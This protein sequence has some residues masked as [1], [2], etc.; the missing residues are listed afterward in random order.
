M[1]PGR[2]VDRKAVQVP[3]GKR[4]V[5]DGEA[6]GR[7]ELR[8][9]R[10]EPGEHL[11][12][13][14]DHAGCEASHV[15]RVR[16]RGQHQPLRLDLAALGPHPH[17]VLARRPLE[18]ALPRPQLGAV[19][20]R[21]VDVRDDAA[22]GHDEAALALVDEPQLGRQAISREPARDLGAV[23]LFVLEAVLEA[24]A[25]GALE[26][27][28]TAF[29]G[30][31]H[32]QQLLAG[33]GLELAPQLVR[34]QHE[35]HVARVLEVRLADDPR[36]AVRGAELVRHVEALETEDALPA[37]REVV[38]RSAPHAADPDDDDVVALHPS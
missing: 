30:A 32:V 25:N 23:E 22:L 13:R 31:R 28:R 10:L 26:D 1:N 9:E 2:A 27:P 34:A 8:P 14:R 12:L 7:E 35:R 20:E 24:R 5:E 29:D 33:L 15:L 11:P 6:V 18:H 16:A 37:P 21:A 17:P 38:E 4:D 3:L 19:R 36:N